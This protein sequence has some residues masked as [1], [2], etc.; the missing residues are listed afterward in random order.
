MVWHIPQIPM[1]PFYAPVQNVREARLLID[2]L[3]W[4]DM[5]QYDEN[6]IKPDYSNVSGLLV[7]ENNEWVEWDNPLAGDTIAEIA[8]T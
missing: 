5:F 2:T 1:E 8:Y 7:F 3:E 6:N 4:Y